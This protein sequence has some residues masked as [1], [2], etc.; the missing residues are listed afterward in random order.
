[1]IAYMLGEANRNKPLRVFDWDKAAR[2]IAERNPEIAIAGLLYDEEWTA[3]VIWRDGKPYKDD[4]TYLASVWAEPTLY[5]D[6]EEIEC[7]CYTDEWNSDTKWPKSAL[8]IIESK[9]VR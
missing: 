4:Y 1:M 9:D 5:I 8:E 7:W 2:I 3:G 6:G